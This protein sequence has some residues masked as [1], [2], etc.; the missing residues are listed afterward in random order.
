MVET[1]IRV[2]RRYLMFSP[3]GREDYVDY[4]LATGNADEAAFQIAAMVNDDKFVS[5]RGRSKHAMWMQLCDIVSKHP[6]EVTSLRVD[7]V[8]R[9]G[10]NRF[11][12]EVGRLWCSLAE[13]YV[14]QGA[15]DKVG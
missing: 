8:L 10:I 4:L 13:F 11:T 5:Q 1:C 14:R 7:P 6:G 9:S 15:F 12:D 2:Y 3:A